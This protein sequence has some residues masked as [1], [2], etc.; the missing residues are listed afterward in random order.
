MQIILAKTAGFCMGVKRAMKI[1]T[2]TA[3]SEQAHVFT[4]GPLIH[5]PQ[6]VDYLKNKGV[7]TL[8]K[9]SEKHDGTLIVRAHG[10]P[11]DEIEKIKQRGFKIV[12]ATCP[13]VVTSQKQI[14]KF[15][16]QGYFICIVG[17]SQHPE[18]LSLQ[19][20][21]PNNHILISSPEE[22]QKAFFPQKVA[23]VGQTTFSSKTYKNIADIVKQKASE[24]EVCDSICQATFERQK[25]ITELAASA[26][27]VV[28]VGGYQSANTKR[29]AE[30]AAQL[31]KKTCQ[32]ETANELHQSL[33]DGAN[34]VVVTAGA[35][36]P[37]FITQQV[38]KR[39]ESI[40]KLG[41][42]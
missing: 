31:C 7:E 8:D 3:E 32:V 33:F 19:S 21:A 42:V 26:D 10:M 20:Y 22:A 4:L 11:R 39:I 40:S 34:K 27:V 35:S 18:I 12:D 28:V 6:A 1:A 36:T 29:L 30:I 25:E 14:Q 41:K 37:D 23:V 9:V 2:E 38:I 15:S 13:H 24:V 5:N 17:D 16:Q